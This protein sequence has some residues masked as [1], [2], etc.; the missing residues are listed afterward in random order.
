MA[1]KKG[2]LLK[3]YQPIDLSVIVIDED[4]VTASLVSQE[5]EIGH[6]WTWEEAT[7]S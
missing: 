6:E 1:T 5:T 4:V 2:R 7:I 3:A